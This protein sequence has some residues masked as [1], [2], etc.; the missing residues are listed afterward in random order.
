MNGEEVVLQCKAVIGPGFVV[1]WR[2]EPI[3]TADFNCPNM[4]N[5]AE[6]SAITISNECPSSLPL[7][8]TCS[9]VYMGILSC[10]TYMSTLT[11]NSNYSSMNG[12]LIQCHF[13][14]GLP[15]EPTSSNISFP[16]KIGSKYNYI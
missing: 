4:E 3:E 1:V 14:S 9:L 6:N 8:G 5:S 15:L 12:G 2:S 13:V 11:F 10:D 7:I 16:L